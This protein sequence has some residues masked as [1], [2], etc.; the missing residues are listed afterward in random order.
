MLNFFCYSSS[1]F[2]RLFLPFVLIFVTYSFHL[3]FSLIFS[4]PLSLIIKIYLFFF[5]E[6]KVNLKV[7]KKSFFYILN[8]KKVAEEE[9][10]DGNLRH[11]V[12]NLFNIPYIVSN[13][14]IGKKKIQTPMAV[15]RTSI[16][17]HQLS[18]LFFRWINIRRFFFLS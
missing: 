6:K 15:S 2:I 3:F 10:F 1:C 13:H 12:K 5:F 14:E 4:A 17:I 18:F 7:I 16:N 9:E 8:Q 11:I